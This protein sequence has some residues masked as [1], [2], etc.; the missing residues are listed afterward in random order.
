[1][2][3]TLRKRGSCDVIKNHSY[4]VMTLTLV[5]IL[6]AHHYLLFN[7][8]ELFLSMKYL[9]PLHILTYTLY[10]LKDDC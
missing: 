1:M 6:L 7:G 9:R 10:I 4:V 8:M 5:R 3:K 2:Q